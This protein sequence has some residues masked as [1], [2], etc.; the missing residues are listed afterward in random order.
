MPAYV[1]DIDLQAPSGIWTHI[2]QEYVAT[3]NQPIEKIAPF[4]LF[5]VDGDRLLASIGELK[6]RVDS[7]VG[8][9]QAGCDKAS[10]RIA[11]LRVLDFDDLG[12][13]FMEYRASYGHEDMGRDLKD[14]HAVKRLRHV[15]TPLN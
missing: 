13:P 4:R 12:T 2:G 15:S 3:L 14:S 8:R 9:M 6:A 11:G 10:V 7:V 1:L 5:E